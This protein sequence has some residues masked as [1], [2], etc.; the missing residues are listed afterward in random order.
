MIYVGQKCRMRHFRKGTADVEI[1]AIKGE[2]IDVV[3]IKGDL[4]GIGAGS[5]RGPGDELRV[6][7][8][9][10]TFVELVE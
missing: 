10:A 9:L 5:Y 1:K 6:R 7:D 4:Q 8:S 2:W 3:V